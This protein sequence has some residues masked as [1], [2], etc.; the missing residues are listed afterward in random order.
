[1]W[2]SNVPISADGTEPGND[3]ATAWS[4]GMGLR[5]LRHEEPL[6][7]HRP[8][9]QPPGNPGAAWCSQRA[10]IAAI[11]ELLGTGGNPHFR[12]FR[13]ISDQYRVPI[14][15]MPTSWSF[16]HLFSLVEFW[17]GSRVATLR[18]INW[19]IGYIGSDSKAES[20]VYSP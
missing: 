17:R 5:C 14:I 19:I 18:R 15:G 1:M 4:S 8:G 6:R 3:F 9:E 10:A 2:P 7:Q 20:F 16:F 13:I 12:S 11:A